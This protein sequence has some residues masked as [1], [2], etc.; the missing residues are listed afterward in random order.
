MQLLLL[1]K[2]AKPNTRNKYC[3]TLLHHSS[4]IMVEES[5]KLSNDP[6]DS[7]RYA[8]TTEYGALV[9]AKYNERRTPMQLAL[10]H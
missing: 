4:C 3:F 6:G 2:G 7:R 5:K 8:P 9:D 10:E 1:D